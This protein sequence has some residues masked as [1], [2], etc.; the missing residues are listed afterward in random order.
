MP[1]KVV[2]CGRSE[3][4]KEHLEK[5]GFWVVVSCE[6]IKYKAGKCRIIYKQKE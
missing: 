2:P 3:E 6:P 5:S 4:M 1:D